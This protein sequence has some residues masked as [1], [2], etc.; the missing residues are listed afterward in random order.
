MIA[1]ISRLQ[2]L[3]PADQEALAPKIASYIDKVEHFRGLIQ[4][5]LD[6]GEAQPLTRE[7]FRDVVKRGRE[8]H[9]QRS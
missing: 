4:E 6:S 3:P 2:T 5:G 1:V 9:A 7:T 8:R